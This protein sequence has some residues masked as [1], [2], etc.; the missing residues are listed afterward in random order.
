MNGFTHFIL[1]S[2]IS[3]LLIC[4]N[5][6]ISRY[7]FP[8]LAIPIPVLLCEMLFFSQHH[9]MDDKKAQKRENKEYDVLQENRVSSKHDHVREK[10]G[11]PCESIYIS[12]YQLGL[13]I[14]QDA[15]TP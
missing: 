1:K 6:D 11:I 9:P 13:L 7:L 12:F 14:L 2:L 8:I 3:Q 4:S 15:Y 10:V 5:N